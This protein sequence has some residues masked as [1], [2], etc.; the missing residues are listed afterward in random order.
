MQQDTNFILKDIFG[1][2]FFNNNIF[3]TYI[4]AKIKAPESTNMLTSLRFLCLPK[5][6]L[7][8]YISDVFYT[9]TSSGQYNET[10][11][12]VAVSYCW[13][14]FPT[15]MLTFPNQDRRISIIDRGVAIEPRCPV[16][17]IL[18]AAD[19]ARIWGIRLLWIDQEW[20]DQKN[21]ADVQNHLQCMHHIYQRAKLTVGVLDFELSNWG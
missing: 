5:E 9:I 10:L 1:Y 18:R 4:A 21:D 13:E 8:S 14:S 7:N 19:F 6:G 17:V 3:Y 11:E 16:E 2:L 12:Y 15:N 20:I